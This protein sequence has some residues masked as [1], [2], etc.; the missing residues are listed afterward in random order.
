V[1]DPTVVP[2]PA[3]VP[4]A[5]VVDP[6][7]SSAQAA[8]TNNNTEINAQTGALFL[9]SPPESVTVFGNDFIT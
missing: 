4:G 3:D 1:L 8:I 2:G 9:I 7:V 5:S 6:A